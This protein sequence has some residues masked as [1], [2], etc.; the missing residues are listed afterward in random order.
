M[1]SH[2]VAFRQ[3]WIETSRCNRYFIY[4]LYRLFGFETRI[5]APV[6]TLCERKGRHHG[7]V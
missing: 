3:M 1:R 4:I 2:H 7:Y 6:I 5:F